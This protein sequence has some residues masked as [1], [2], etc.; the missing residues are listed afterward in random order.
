MLFPF[1]QDF[2]LATNSINNILIII[3][4]YDR[5]TYLVML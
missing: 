5:Y 4:I 2:W 3:I 1:L